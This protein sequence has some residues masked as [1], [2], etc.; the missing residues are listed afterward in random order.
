[1]KIA[2]CKC[3]SV[4]E[5]GHA[6]NFHGDVSFYWHYCEGETDCGIC[7]P[8]RKT[9]E[10]A[11]AAWNELIGQPAEP[12]AGSVRVTAYAIISTSGD[13]AING[14]RGG[15]RDKITNVLFDMISDFGENTT[16]HPVTFDIP[17]PQPAE[18]KGS[19]E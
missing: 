18:I 2:N 6:E 1:M 12:A 10:E 7:G 11:L 15:E 4:P 9:P 16:V 3:G 13:W 17:L 8:S 14:W 5:M 19:V